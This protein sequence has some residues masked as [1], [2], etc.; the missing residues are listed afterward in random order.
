M[1][2]VALSAARSNCLLISAVHLLPTYVPSAVEGMAIDP[3]TL[4]SL[5][6]ARID[7]VS[8]AGGSGVKRIMLPLAELTRSDAAAVIR[9]TPGAL[10][11]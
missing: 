8:V 6:L 10:N 7:S 11:V 3:P 9:T 5:R 4:K 1:G 2:D